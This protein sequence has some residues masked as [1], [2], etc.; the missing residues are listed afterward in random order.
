MAARKKRRG[1][2]KGCSIRQTDDS[3]RSFGFAVECDGDLVGF[4]ETRKGKGSWVVD[5]VYVDEPYQRRRIGTALYEKAAA[6][7]CRRGAPLASVSRSKGARSH[8]FWAKQLRKGRAKKRGDT[9]TL[10]CPAPA[11]LAGLGKIQQMVSVEEAQARIRARHK[12]VDLSRLPPHVRPFAEYM[13]QR[14][15]QSVTAR[16]V[17]KAYVLT[18]SSVQRRSVRRPS[19]CRTWPGYKPLPRMADPK[20]VRPEDTMAALLF[21]DEGHRY[22]DAAAR[23]VIDEPAIEKIAER[24]ACFGHVYSQRAP[25]R[26]DAE[27]AQYWKRQK[28]LLRQDMRRAARL[29]LRANEV[30]RVLRAPAD[31]YWRWVQK[32]LPGIS[33]AK[34]G[35]FASLL[36]RGDIPTFDAREIQLWR[37][38]KKG[39]F[40]P[41]WSEVRRLRQR[42]DA[43]PMELPSKYE[44]FRSHLVH[45]A[46]WDAYNEGP[47]P[48]KTTHGS[49]IRA[50]QFAGVKHSR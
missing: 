29:G 39:S 10:S 9:Y 27:R 7:A 25:P 44:P 2:P 36:G 15:G 19:V 24:H 42:F 40:E 5:G 48:T 4:L 33:A 22:L 8:D 26:D 50:M 32:E 12:G 16:D 38:R 37:K 20:M 6:E 35:F 14:Q 30:R 21:T 1:L 41:T 11:D 28:N 49:I 23:G 3:R 18:R 47:R 45:H 17:V 13:R 43:F 34:A 46:L 31:D